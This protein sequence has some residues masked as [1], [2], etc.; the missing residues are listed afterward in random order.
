MAQ[1]RQPSSSLAL[2]SFVWK[3]T[4]SLA[5]ANIHRSGSAAPTFALTLG[6]HG[7]RIIQGGICVYHISASC[8][9]VFVYITHEV[10]NFELRATLLWIR[11]VAILH[12]VI[13]RKGLDGYSAFWHFCFDSYAFTILCMMMGTFVTTLSL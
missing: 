12:F 9:L 10:S 1:S 8:L 7:A 4:H 11:F 3:Y 6:H 13:E 2:F 5:A